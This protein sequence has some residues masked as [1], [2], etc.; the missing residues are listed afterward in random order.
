METDVNGKVYCVFSHTVLMI[1]LL[2]IFIRMY[3]VVTFN[4]RTMTKDTVISGYRVPKGVRN[5]DLF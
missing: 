4:G 5:N 2:S 1:F 3:P